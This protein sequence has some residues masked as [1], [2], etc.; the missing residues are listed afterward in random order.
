MNGGIHSLH[1]KAKK[2]ISMSSQALRKI[3]GKWSSYF[4]VTVF[5]ITA[6]L[7]GSFVK[8]ANAFLSR[9]SIGTFLGSGPACE[10]LSSSSWLLEPSS[11]LL[12]EVAVVAKKLRGLSGRLGAPA[13]GAS[14]RLPG[15]GGWG[16]TGLPQSL[17]EQCDL[18]A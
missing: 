16:E 9:A 13:S 8:F 4:L 5:N 14:Y 11:D 15:I 7:S 2:I 17:G 3:S 6:L 1:I 12:D 10:V 18:Q